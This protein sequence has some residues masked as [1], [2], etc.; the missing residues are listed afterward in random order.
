MTTVI[1]G[2]DV[3][4]KTKFA[5]KQKQTNKNLLGL[6]VSRITRKQISVVKPLICA[7]LLWHQAN[8]HTAPDPRKGLGPGWEF[9]QKS[10]STGEACQ[11][12]ISLILECRQ[13]AGDHNSH[14][15]NKNKPHEF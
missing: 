13:T 8:K 4:G 6:L 9:I 15:L 11:S 5:K 12:D 1:T 2:K 7:I 3:A 14:L 10:P